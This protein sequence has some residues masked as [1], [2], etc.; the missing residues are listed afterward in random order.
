ME[1]FE[2]PLP[3]IPDQEIRIQQRQKQEYRHI[4]TFKIWRGMKLY[5]VNLKTLEVK[6]EKINRQALIDITKDVIYKS[7]VIYNPD[8]KYLLA[9]NESNALRKS[10]II[11]KKLYS[12]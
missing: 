1:G 10:V 5:S 6:E 12:L 2:G 11:L 4:G 7:K 3:L 9:I 8:C